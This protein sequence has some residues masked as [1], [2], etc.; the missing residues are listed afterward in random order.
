M[1]YFDLYASYPDHTIA[2]AWDSQIKEADEDS[3]L[4]ET[5]TAMW[6]ANCLRASRRVTRSC[7]P[8][9]AA[10]AAPLPASHCTFQRTGRD[11]TGTLAAGRTT[12]TA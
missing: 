1:N 2:A 9:P 7:A 8:C 3:W 10:R 5:L 6:K 4:A 12:T 11:L